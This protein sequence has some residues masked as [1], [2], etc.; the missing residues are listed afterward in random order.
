MFEGGKTARGGEYGKQVAESSGGVYLR[1]SDGHIALH[2]FEVVKEIPERWVVRDTGKSGVLQ[3]INSE[4]VR[5]LLDGEPHST[6]HR[7]DDVSE[8][9]AD[10]EIELLT[11]SPLSE[12]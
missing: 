1:F 2:S 5:L 6:V 9:L 3:F 12:L 8:E 4:I 7:R 10:W 11:G